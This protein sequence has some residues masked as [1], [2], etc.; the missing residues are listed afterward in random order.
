MSTEENKALHRIFTEEVMN[1]GR[2]SAADKFVATE[3]V[4]HGAFPGLPPG[5]EGFK[6]SMAILRAGFPDVH[7][8]LD[9]E[10]AEGDK[11]VVRTTMHGTHR[12]TFAGIPPTGKQVSVQTI[13]IV[14]IAH[15]KIVEH[16]GLQ[17]NLSMM[18][19]LGVVSAPA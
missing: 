9:D 14:R 12:G 5:L 17:D 10:I 6:Q 16:W 13:D 8:T 1:L 2:L 3:L 19:L 4:D 15:G 18:Q 11:V 7:F